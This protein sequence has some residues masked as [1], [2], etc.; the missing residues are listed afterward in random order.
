ML[1]FCSHSV[2]CNLVIYQMCCFSPLS[3]S[4]IF[5]FF[6]FKKARRLYLPKPLRGCAAGR[7]GGFRTPGHEMA[8][9]QFP[10]FASTRPPVPLPCGGDA[11]RHHSIADAA[12]GEGGL[13]CRVPPHNQLSVP[14]DVS[15]PEQITCACRPPVSS[16]S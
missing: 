14:P 16:K 8:N 15:V 2:D 6:Y 4:C 11:A 9:G 12:G 7:L 5:L 3:C 1:D 10:G 13:W